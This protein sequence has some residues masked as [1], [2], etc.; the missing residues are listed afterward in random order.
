MKTNKM[1]KILALGLVLVMV[2]SMFAGCSPAEDEGDEAGDVPATVTE[3]VKVAALNGPTGMAMVKLMDQADKYEVTTFQAP[4]DVT[5]K[6]I[7]GEV[8]VAAVPSNLAAVLYNKTEGK[9]VAVGNGTLLDN[10]ERVALEVAV[11]DSII[12]S[13]YAGTEVKYEGND[14][15][16]LRESDILA[17]IG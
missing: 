6:I 13:K 7:S 15:L 1:K 2:L 17:I 9:V 5:G 14:Y 3:I 4:T 12:F 16:I 8:D 11:G 10:G